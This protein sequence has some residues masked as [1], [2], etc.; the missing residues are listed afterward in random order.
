MVITEHCNAQLD[1]CHSA[2]AL[3]RVFTFKTSVYQAA[4]DQFPKKSDLMS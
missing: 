4:S 1:D 3:L 2:E